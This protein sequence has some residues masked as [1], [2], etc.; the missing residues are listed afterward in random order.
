[1]HGARTSQKCPHDKQHKS[2]GDARRNAGLDEKKQLW[3]PR[4]E[5]E[6]DDDKHGPS[7]HGAY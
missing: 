1:M 7:S 5:E 2:D 6:P 3:R 4:N